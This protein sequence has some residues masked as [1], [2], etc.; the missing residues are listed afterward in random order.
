MAVP[1]NEGDIA[2]VM[3]RRTTTDYS[4][5]TPLSNVDEETINFDPSD[6]FKRRKQSL[7]G[8]CAQSKNSYSI[9]NHNVAVLRSMNGD[10]TKAFDTL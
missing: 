4:E 10:F 9:T 6:M 8:L 7:S 5:P 1:S 2:M 3:Q